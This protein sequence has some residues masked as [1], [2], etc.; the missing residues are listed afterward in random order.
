[1]WTTNPLLS[2]W[3]MWIMSAGTGLTLIGIAMATGMDRSADV[4][5]LAAWLSGGVTLAGLG[6]GAIGTGRGRSGTHDRRRR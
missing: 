6:H 4:G 5:Q 1:M 2:D 3:E